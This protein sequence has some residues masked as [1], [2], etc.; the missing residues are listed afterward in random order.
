MPYEFGDY[1]VPSTLAT[2]TASITTYLRG[3]G[4]WAASPGDMLKSVYDNS[5][6][7]GIVD[8]AEAL[9]GV[10]ALNYARRDIA[11]TYGGVPYFSA[12]GEAVQI[13]AS[14]TLDHAYAAFYARSGSSVRSAFFGFPA[15][16]S[17]VMYFQNETAGGSM[18]FGAAGLV[19]ITN[20]AEVGGTLTIAGFLAWHAG[21]LKPGV[22]TPVKT[23]TANYTVLPND[24]TIFVD[25][26]AGAVTI[27]LPTAASAIVGGQGQRVKVKK[28]DTTPNPVTI[29]ATG[30]QI[31]GAATGV[32]STPYNAF[33]FIPVPGTV[34]WGG[35]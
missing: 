7:A 17:N 2:G 16:A 27:T 32:I 3:D 4:T 1:P 12:G 29:T 30:G 11:Q 8:N 6:T 9:G 24:A 20:N 35:F 23:V 10:A 33:E 28:I 14:A 13:A 31:D 34:N 22:T 18:I 5:G 26:T 25:A 15:N 21:N 19:S